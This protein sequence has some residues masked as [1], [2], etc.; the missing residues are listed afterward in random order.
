MRRHDS[1]IRL[2]THLKIY[3]L[4]NYMYSLAELRP[5]MAIVLEGTPFLVLRAQHSK[6]AR[7]T[8]VAKTS[9]RNLLT[10][11]VIPMTFQGQEKLEPADIGFTKAQFLY[12]SDGEYHFMDNTDFAQFSFTED[13]LGD[14]KYFLIDGMEVDIQNFEGRPISVK[15]P[16]KVVLE[17]TETDPGVKG[18][19]ASGGSKPAL[20]QTGLTVSVPFFINVGDKIRV[21]TESQEYVERA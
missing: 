12:N 13:D 1:Q 4:N 16:P 17:V 5:G 9:M 15:I 2:F 3:Y 7:G 8:G 18:D 20:T 14:Q 21:N 11:A 6:Q 19:T 10:G